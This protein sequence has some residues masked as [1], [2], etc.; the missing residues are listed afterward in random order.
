MRK[1]GLF[2]ILSLALLGVG[3]SVLDMDLIKSKESFKLVNIDLD[4]HEVS[5]DAQRLVTDV[6]VF[7]I[8]L[9]DQIYQENPEKNHLLSPLSAAIAMAML[10]NGANGATR[11]E[12]IDALGVEVDVLN[13]SFNELMNIYGAIDEQ[14]DENRD[15]AT[16]ENANSLW[17][18]P[19]LKA[20]EDYVD[21]LGKYYDAQFFSVNFKSK[22]TVDRMNQ[23]VEERTNGLL[24][25]T[26]KEF[27]KETVA[28]LINTLYFKGQ[29]T[30]SFS[31]ELTTKEDFQVSDAHT[32]TVDMMHKSLTAPYFETKTA[33]VAVLDYYGAR[34]LVFLPKGEV[35][36]MMTDSMVLEAI[37]SNQ[38][39]DY[40]HQ[41]LNVSMP[42][43]DFEAKNDLKTLLMNLGVISVFDESAADLSNML[44]SDKQVVVSKVYQ[45][46]RIKV[47]EHGTEAAAVTVMEIELTSGPAEPETPID[48]NCDHPYMIVIQ[49]SITG[50]NL[51]MG[52]VNNPND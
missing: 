23:W 8:D 42:K 38:N 27:S 36:D 49:D 1:A 4:D 31:E 3:C 47:D 25:D 48:F 33:Q 39:I 35:A 6:N 26:F 2:F 34:M 50:T 24:K 37:T 41:R 7:G 32:E 22:K 9:F 44:A 51:F 16:I 20:K 12:I 11:D 13:P 52:V 21:V 46:A 15:Y 19:D 5:T 29:W 14:S 43:I 28:A 10:E 30:D 45:N 17:V 18:R 40:H